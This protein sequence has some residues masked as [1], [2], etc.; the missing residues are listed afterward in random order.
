MM[1]SWYEWGKSWRTEWAG[2][3]LAV[4]ALIHLFQSSIPPQ[5]LLQYSPY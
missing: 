3:A 1:C 2:I 4:A 5:T